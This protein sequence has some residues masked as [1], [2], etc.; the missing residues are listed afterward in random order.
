MRSTLRR[1]PL[2][3]ALDALGRSG[4][5]HVA[6]AENGDLYL[7]SGAT[8]DLD[9]DAGASPEP[10]FD[11]CIVRLRR[12]RTR[13]TPTIWRPQTRSRAVPAPAPPALPAPPSPWA[14]MSLSCRSI[15]RTL[16][17]LNFASPFRYH[18]FDL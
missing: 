9:N 16:N 5:Q 18:A 8:R 3:F 4:F 12:E 2:L 10:C 7:A 13:W 11:A 15:W 14:T 17:A 6:L 1:V